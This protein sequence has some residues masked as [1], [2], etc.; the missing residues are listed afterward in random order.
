MLGK[1]A[2]A[3]GSAGADIDSILVVDRARG[4]AIDD[5]VVSLP[6]GGLADRLVSA[7]GSVRG[8]TVEAVQRHHG[9]LRMHDD[10]AVLD[11]AA[12]SD[13]PLASLASS[14]PELMHA[15]YCL[16]VA[17]RAG[18]STA[19][20]LAATAA[21]PQVPIRGD[22]LPVTAR[23]IPAAQLWADPDVAGPDSELVVVPFRE[24]AAIVLARIGGPAFRPAELTRLTHLA[25]VA[26]ALLPIDETV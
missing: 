21:A 12:S 18:A 23:E 22:W 24:S 4:Y 2:S 1:L 7:A 16:I 26:N 13:A 11:L 19:S 15:S 5:L 17:K 20:T 9:R 3:L 6:T 25:R 14:L 8:V 10:L